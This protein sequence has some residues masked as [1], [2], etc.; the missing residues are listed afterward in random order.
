MLRHFLLP[1]KLPFFDF[2]TSVS[3][4]I[5]NFALLVSKINQVNGFLSIRDRF[6]IY[7][8]IHYYSPP[9]QLEKERR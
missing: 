4:A 2:L 5:D 3:V 9:P 8:V 6:E 1:F 7:I